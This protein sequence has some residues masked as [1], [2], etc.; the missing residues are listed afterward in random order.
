MARVCLGQ[1]STILIFNM[2]QLQH[3]IESFFDAIDVSM[4][5]SLVNSQNTTQQEQ[6]MLWL[7]E[8]MGKVTERERT[9]PRGCS[10]LARP[11]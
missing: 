2:C 3:F 11:R 5:V 7:G 10:R 1:K 4:V 6:F 9:H 8:L